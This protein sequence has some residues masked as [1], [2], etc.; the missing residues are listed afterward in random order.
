MTAILLESVL[1]SHLNF[2]EIVS[3]KLAEVLKGKRTDCKNFEDLTEAINSTEVK[4]A[5]KNEKMSKFT[6]KL[7]AFVYACLIDFPSSNIA[8]ETITTTIFFP[9]CEPNY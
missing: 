2:D 8:Y 5:N 7:Y 4:H 9:K 6:Q 1:N 3:D